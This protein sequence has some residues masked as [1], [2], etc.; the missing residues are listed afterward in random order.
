MKI[1]AIRLATISVPLRV[2][3]RTAVRSV[4][5]IHDLI[6]EIHTDEG[7]IGYGEAPPTGLV[8]GDTIESMT[9]AIKHHI[10]PALIGKSIEDFENLLRILDKSVQHNTSAKAAV[11][12]A[13]YDL[14]AQSLRVPL[15]RSLGGN[16]EG[17][18]TDITISVNEPDEMVRDSINATERGYQTLKIKVGNDSKKDIER[19]SKIRE[20]IGYD[21]DLRIDANQG[22]KPKEAVNILNQMESAGLNIEFVEQPVIQHDFAGLKYI[23][24]RVS[25]PV[26]ADEAVYTARDAQYL[27]ENHCC[28][29]INIKLMKTGGIRKALD[30][31]TIAEMHG[32]ECMLGCMLESK[33]S[34][35]AA[36]HLASAR[37]NTITKIDLD[38]PVLCSEDPIQGGAIFNESNISLP[39]TPGL[40]IISIDGLKYLD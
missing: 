30:I 24:E 27:L 10:A 22:W 15:Y 9:G 39:D 8:T 7:F 21:V 5:S 16:G 29:L 33:V 40:G 38:G 12:M 34:V 20:A 1:T 25:I 18:K 19:M 11:D 37:K 4:D 32:V 26:M 6:V 17:I 2:P 28:D 3:F 36:V 35:T 31:C 14:F 23:T 13:L